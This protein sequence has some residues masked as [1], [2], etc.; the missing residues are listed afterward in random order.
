MAEEIIEQQINAQNCQT[1]AY[2][3]H[4]FVIIAARPRHPKCIFGTAI[5]VTI[6]LHVEN[7]FFSL[8]TAR[9]QKLVIKNKSTKASRTI[10][11][12]I[13]R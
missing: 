4:Y 11:G 2:P 3:E 13:S 5:L 6:R 1:Y 8:S 7:R 9:P 10:V 12:S